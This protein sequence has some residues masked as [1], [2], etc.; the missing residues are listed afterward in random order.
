MHLSL[1]KDECYE[2]ERFYKNYPYP[3]CEAQLEEYNEYCFLLCDMTMELTRLLN[4]ILERIREKKTNFHI[5]DG[6]L[7]INSIERTAVEYQKTEKSNCPY[8][9]IEQFVKIRSTRNC[10]YSKTAHLNFI[11]RQSSVT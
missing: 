10:C 7:I 8:L 11:D 6:I 4:L 9:G 3:D 1:R 2:I 5:E